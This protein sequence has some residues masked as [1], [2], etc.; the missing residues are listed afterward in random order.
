MTATI[1]HVPSET[2]RRGYSFCIYDDV[3]LTSSTD[4]LT[5]SNSHTATETDNNLILY[6][7]IG[8]G[9]PRR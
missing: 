1:A 8:T 3:S 2:G 9:K 6:F 7:K 4:T 5:G